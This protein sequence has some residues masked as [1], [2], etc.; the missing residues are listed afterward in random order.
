MTK[1]T[2]DA[3]NHFNV[4]FV[5]YKTNNTPSKTME[6]NQSQ[7]EPHYNMVSNLQFA[8]E[9]ITCC[10]IIIH[11][12]CQLFERSAVCQR[13]LLYV[14]VCHDGHKLIATF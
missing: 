8:D 9:R 2:D 12:V 6:T 13:I 11:L 7:S 3:Q 5:L 14:S 10:Y 4:M 1:G